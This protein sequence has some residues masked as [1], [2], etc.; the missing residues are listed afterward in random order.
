VKCGS[1]QPSAL[2]LRLLLSGDE[3]S[4]EFIAKTAAKL[5]LAAEHG[6]YGLYITTNPLRMDGLGCRCPV[7][8]AGYSFVADANENLLPPRQGLKLVLNIR[9][10]A[11]GTEMNFDYR[12]EWFK[13]EMV[14]ELASGLLSVL[15]TMVEKPDLMMGEITLSPDTKTHSVDLLAA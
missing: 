11:A 12:T 10:N 5:R 9:R 6:L 4:S 14:D 13:R 1:E 8:D 7:L 15:Q 3:S 2:P